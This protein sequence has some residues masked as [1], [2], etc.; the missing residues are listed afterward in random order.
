MNKETG[1]ST[2][3]FTIF[4]FFWCVIQADVSLQACVKNC[5]THSDTSIW[6]QKY[7]MVPCLFFGRHVHITIL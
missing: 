1:H 5:P 6:V 4:M 2:V 7:A 3:F